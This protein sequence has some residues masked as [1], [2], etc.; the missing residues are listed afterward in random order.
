MSVTLNSLGVGPA[1]LLSPQSIF[2]VSGQCLQFDFAFIIQNVTDS[3]MYSLDAIL[4]TVATVV[5]DMQSTIASWE[6]LPV[7]EWIQL[8]TG[9]P[10]GQYR[11]QCEILSKMADKELDGLP[12]LHFWLADITTRA[13]PD[14]GDGQNKCT[15]RNKSDNSGM[16]NTRVF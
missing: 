3:L 7:N 8:T 13:C 6:H 5:G 4:L 9:L 12:D 1:R 10:M 15:S 11:L 2:S 16:M 14:T